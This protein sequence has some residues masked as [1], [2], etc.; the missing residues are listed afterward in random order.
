MKA[1]TRYEYETTVSTAMGEFPVAATARG[2]SRIEFDRRRGRRAAARREI[3]AAERKQAE[4]HA[5][6]AVQQLQ[7]Y[8]AGKRRTFDLTV[9]F[10]G[11]ELQ[12]KVWHGLQQIPFG[13]TLTYGE[14]AR[15]V[16]FP[17]AARAVGAACGSNPLPI[18]IPCHRVIGSD[19]SLHGFGGGLWR[20]Q[21]LLELEGA[22]QKEE[23]PAQKA[24][25]FAA[26]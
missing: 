14:L 20:K 16:G 1:T 24:L 8:F 15:R 4:A 3:P 22:R 13:K 17:R 10:A 19:G 26:R 23:K 21:A 2:V 6:A 9:D 25:A 7:E 5:R 12:E 11:S 18:V